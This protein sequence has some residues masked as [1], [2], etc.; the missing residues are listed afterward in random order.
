MADNMH[1]R[2]LLLGLIA[3]V[4]AYANNHMQYDAHSLLSAAIAAES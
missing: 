1:A 3:L 4:H 2:Q